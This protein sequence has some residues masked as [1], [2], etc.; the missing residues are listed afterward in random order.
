MSSSSASSPRFRG[1]SA[2]AY[3]IRAQANTP[4]SK[5]GQFVNYSA[6]VAA[7][8][9]ALDIEGKFKMG[10][11]NA[12]SY[13]GGASP[14][15]QWYVACSYCGKGNLVIVTSQVDISSGGTTANSLWVAPADIDNGFFVA[16]TAAPVANMGFSYIVVG[17]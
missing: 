17:K 4:E 13:F 12:G 14:A 5:A 2:S 16:R 3:G 1:A 6:Q 15:T 9:Y 8:G 10:T 11:D 7:P